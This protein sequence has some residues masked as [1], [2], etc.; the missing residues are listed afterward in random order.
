ML[1]I[2]KKSL[3]LGLGVASVTKERVES[4]VDELIEKCQLSKDEK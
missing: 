3:Y 1:D 4:V 2:I